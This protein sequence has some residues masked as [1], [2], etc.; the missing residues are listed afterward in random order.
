M[1]FQV[2]VLLF[3]ALNSWALSEPKQ[4]W[5]LKPWSKTTRQLVLNKQEEKKKNEEEE[6]KVVTA[7]TL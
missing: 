3:K 1:L 4:S 5:E 7:D 2:S 6:E